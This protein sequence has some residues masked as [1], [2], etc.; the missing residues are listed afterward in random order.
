MELAPPTCRR[1]TLAAALL[2]DAVEVLSSRKISDIIGMMCTPG[3]R[4]PTSL[5]QWLPS[6]RWNHSMC[7]RPVSMPSA[8]SAVRMALRLRARTAMA[9][10]TA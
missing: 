8:V 1:V 2:H 6:R 5:T 10:V 4:S 7:D 9:K 3:G